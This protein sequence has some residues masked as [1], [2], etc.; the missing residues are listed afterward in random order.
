MQPSEK[1]K[2]K[3]TISVQTFSPPWKKSQ[4]KVE[5]GLT[6]EQQKTLSSLNIDAPTNNRSTG[7]PKSLSL[8]FNFLGRSKNNEKNQQITHQIVFD[9]IA[10]LEKFGTERKGVFRESGSAVQVKLLKK[11]YTKGFVFDQSLFYLPLDLFYLL[12]DRNFFFL[13]LI[14]F[15]SHRQDNKFGRNM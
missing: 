7:F 1:K 13:P 11:A 6:Q 8:R 2:S 10:Y 14:F 15:F 12:C 5:N 4:N 3:K 9:C